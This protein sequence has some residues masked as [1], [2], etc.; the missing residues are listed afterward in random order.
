[1]SVI[2]HRLTALSRSTV[3]IAQ[4]GSSLKRYNSS[5]TSAA[6]VNDDSSNNGELNTHLFQPV[7][8]QGF[9]SPMARTTT[10]LDAYRAREQVKE[11][12]AKHGG[13]PNAQPLSF[14]YSV[15]NEKTPVIHDRTRDDS[16]TS[17]VLPFKSDEWFMDAY[18]NSYGRLRIGQIFQDLDSLAGVIAYK[19][20]A[21]SEPILVTASVDRIYMLK[22]LD[23]I[24]AADVVLS[25]NVTYT[26]RSS[27]EIT[28][29]ASTSSVQR[30]DITKE[31]DI[32]NEDIFLTA[33]FTF[34]ARHPVTQRSYAINHLICR[35]EAEEF[36]FKRAERFNAAKKEES[37]KTALSLVP[38]SGEES[39]IV[40]N[41]WLKNCEFRENPESRPGHITDMADT[42]I[43][44]T[45]IMQPQYRNRHS[46]MIFGGYLLRQTFELAYACAAAFSNA[47]PR[48]V[49]LDSTTF[50]SPVPVGCVLY[51]SAS[52]A[53]T[54]HISSDGPNITPDNL[55]IKTTPIMETNE[56]YSNPGT[57]IQVCVD[58]RSHH[59]DDTSNHN[60]GSFTYTFFVAKDS[61]A[62]EF[63]AKSQG[64]GYLSVLPQSY[65]EMMKYLEGRRRALETKDY[66]TY[67]KGI[68]APN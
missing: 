53:Y 2:S 42:L 15:C 16:F 27:M 6:K 45:M 52:V 26:G 58:S 31:S 8:S 18:I 33:N 10:W 25:G 39:S 40:H 12:A 32:K 51:L 34:V 63:S 47:V 19:H 1:M 66:F 43:R 7:A 49:S 14:K 17:V 50:K 9:K 61:S 24:N 46:Y 13:D 41:L 55:N 35:N 62:H 59:I 38:P 11:N 21:P 56:Q 37:K 5:L 57:L 60:T 29:K 4:L 3:R 67:K 48:F 44:S 28:I 68:N 36:D 54:E 20:C 22:R 30:P 65:S 23:N 64:S